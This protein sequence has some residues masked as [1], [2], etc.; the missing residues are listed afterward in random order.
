[1]CRRRFRLL[2]TVLKST[3]S[4]PSRLPEE[5]DPGKAKPAK[6]RG[7]LKAMV[8]GRKEGLSGAVSAVSAEFISVEAI[9][10]EAI[11][12]EA[13]SNGSTP[14]SLLSRSNSVRE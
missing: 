7:W 12:V 14:E 1:M 2:W 5:E 3:S 8:V 13:I 9:L 11:L 4:G 6:G 10:V